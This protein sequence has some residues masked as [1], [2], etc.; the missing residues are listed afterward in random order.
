MC[1]HLDV[2]SKDVLPPQWAWHL[3]KHSC[4]PLATK[5]APLTS[6]RLFAS[7]LGTS[8]APHLAQWCTSPL[9]VH[10]ALRVLDHQEGWKQVPRQLSLPL[11]LCLLMS[12]HQSQKARLQLNGLQQGQDWIARM[13]WRYVQ[14][15]APCKNE[16]VVPWKRP[17]ALRY[18][19]NDCG[20]LC[21]VRLLCWR[22]SRSRCESFSK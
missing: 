5:S 10:P 13:A 2:V 3:D 19:T 11:V 8:C 7:Y 15:Q 12:P 14:K 20:R 1:V 9:P 21:H 16:V 22:R 17:N 18:F 6:K 4:S